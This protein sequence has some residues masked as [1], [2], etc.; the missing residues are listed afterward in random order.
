MKQEISQYG[1]IHIEWQVCPEVFNS[2][3]WET[4]ETEVELEV[5]KEDSLCLK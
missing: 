1:G 5:Y 3:E 4:F 2:D